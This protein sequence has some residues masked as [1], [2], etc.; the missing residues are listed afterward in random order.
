M[1]PTIT[2]IGSA[3]I[4]YVTQMPELPKVGETVSDGKFFQAFGGK[5][6]N[7][8]VAAARAGA[9]VHFVGALGDD[10]TAQSYKAS[11]EADQMDCSHLSL[12]TDVPSGS[13]LIMFDAKGDNYISVAPGANLRLTAERVL[14]AED[15]IVASDWIILQMEIPV[16]ANR[17]VLELATKYNRPVLL[18]YAPANDLILELSPAIHGL[19]VNE[20]E[21]AELLEQSFDPAD[22][23]AVRKVGLQLREQGRHQFV[24]I[25]LGEKGVHLCDASGSQHLPVFPVQPVDTTAAGDT[26]CGAL[27]VALAE[28]RSLIEAA[29]Y[30]SAASA[31]SVTQ[32]G[33]Q[34]SI[35]TRE[36]TETFLETH[37]A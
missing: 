9:A 28:G 20:H 10:L 8:A 17:A 4:D 7:Q 5:G 32:A 6:A 24:A 1:K 12:E 16:A 29:R 2:V 14:A 37:D 36:A 31:L 23:T 19:V 3:N 33:A 34:P 27:S 13:A 30:A 35:P 11:L 15:F 21:A 25:T 18:N 22:E 26:F